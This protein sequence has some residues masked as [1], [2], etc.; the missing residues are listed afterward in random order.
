MKFLYILLITV[1]AKVAFT[2][3]DSLARHPTAIEFENSKNKLTKNG[4]MVL[5]SWAGANLIAGAV[6]YGVSTN[7]QEKEFHLMNASWGAINLA[8]ALPGLIGKPKPASTLYDLQ[9]KQTT[10]EKL[11][12][13]NAVLDV[14]YISGGF[15]LKEMAKNQTDI[16]LQQRLN[17][18]GNSVILQGAGL[19]AFDVV[20]TIL[21]NRQR[22]KHLD[23]FLQKTSFSFSGNYA[24]ISYSF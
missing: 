20:M 12:L 17:G 23:P 9:K 14:V 16:A 4:M 1:L 21:T 5:S 7:H 3:N 18:F 6:G 22:K 13:A 11:F 10:T 15:Y 24:R 2:Q 8:I 19:M